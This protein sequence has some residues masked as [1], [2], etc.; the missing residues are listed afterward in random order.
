MFHKQVQQSLNPTEPDLRYRIIQTLR[1]AQG[2]CSQQSSRRRRRRDAR[3]YQF[4]FS[5]TE[6]PNCAKK[7]GKVKNKS[8]HSC[9][10]YES[11]VERNGIKAWWSMVGAAIFRLRTTWKECCA[12]SYER[13]YKGE[14]YFFSTIATS[15][16]S[17]RAAA[18][19][20][21]NE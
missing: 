12:Y 14:V 16:A 3:R 17:I 8:L 9:F 20:S 2:I 6:A 19:E 4:T 7:N 5:F 18:R 21:M 1:G 11:H 13:N 15:G 10:R